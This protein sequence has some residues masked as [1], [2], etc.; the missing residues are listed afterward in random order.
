MSI[1]ENDHVRIKA[2]GI[3]GVVVDVPRKETD[4]Y[5]TIESDEKGTP[6]GYGSEDSYKLYDCLEDELENNYG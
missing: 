6:G 4:K 5:F 2:S 3:C 1:K